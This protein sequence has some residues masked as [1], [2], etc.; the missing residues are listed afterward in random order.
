VYGLRC[1]PGGDN[2]GPLFGRLLCSLILVFVNGK[3]MVVNKY[4]VGT[5]CCGFRFYGLW[6]CGIW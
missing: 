6:V 3:K 4:N 5:V 2:N 1:V